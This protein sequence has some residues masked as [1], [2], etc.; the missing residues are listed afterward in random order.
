MS[1]SVTADTMSVNSCPLNGNGPLQ[2]ENDVSMW[3][4]GKEHIILIN[5]EYTQLHIMQEQY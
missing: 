5:T 2:Y 1:A 3:H 4:E